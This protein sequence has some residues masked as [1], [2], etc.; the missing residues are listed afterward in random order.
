MIEL[1]NLLDNLEIEFESFQRYKTP[2]TLVVFI[3]KIKEKELSLN[4]L[5]KVILEFKR[6]LESSLRKTDLL[7]RYKNSLIIMLRNTNIDRSKGFIN[8]FFE[9]IENK[10][11]ENYK[12]LSYQ[13][14]D[15]TLLNLTVKS[16][17]ISFSDLIEDKNFIIINKFDKNGLIN[18]FDNMDEEE[19]VYEIWE[20]NFPVEK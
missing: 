13:N 1:N 12:E 9:N 17:I 6:Y 18:L 19:K 10:I 3:L 8:R 4:Y 7:Y 5:H 15:F 16:Y 2:L 11:K 14:E 20:L